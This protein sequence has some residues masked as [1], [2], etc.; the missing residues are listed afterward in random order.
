MTSAASTESPPTLGGEAGDAAGETGRLL[1]GFL[2]LASG[3][4]GLPDDAIT[5]NLSSLEIV[6]VSD[7]LRFFPNLDAIDLSDNKL[8]YKEVLEH[9]F[10][11][12]RL[13]KINL[14]CNQIGRLNCRRNPLATHI[15]SF[16]TLQSLDLSYN[17]LH[18]DVLIALASLPQLQR[19]NLTANCV[20]SIPPEE[21]LDGFPKLQEL[22]LDSNDLVQFDQWRSLDCLRS[23]RHLSLKHNRI[24]RL[25]DEEAADGLSRAEYE[26]FVKLEVLELQDNDFSGLQQHTNEF[27]FAS[28]QVQQSKQFEADFSLLQR[29]PALRTV[30]VSQVGFPRRLFHARV[31]TE[32][33]KRWYMSGNQSHTARDKTERAR[34]NTRGRRTFRQVKSTRV[35]RFGAMGGEND[36]FR[37]SA[38]SSFGDFLAT[39]NSYRNTSTSVGPGAGPSSP[40]ATMQ[41][42]KYGSDEDLQK[43]L[44]TDTLVKVNARSEK[45]SHETKDK[46]KLVVQPIDLIGKY[47]DDEAMDEI[48]AR[49]RAQIDGLVER[50]VAGKQKKTQQ[51]YLQQIPFALSSESQNIILSVAK[52]VSAQTA[53]HGENEDYFARY[54]AE[55]ILETP[56]TPPEVL[57]QRRTRN[58]GMHGDSAL[59]IQDRSAVSGVDVPID[60]KR[61][62]EALQDAMN[63]DDAT[64]A[65]GALM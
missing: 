5:A 25:R 28:S 31:E 60:I 45:M 63:R 40:N 57:Q 3:G 11:T 10:L 35:T 34:N 61:S 13:T 12:P 64:W 48:F 36:T 37:G 44:Y 27:S 33:T 21:S 58:G 46:E 55:Q 4:F 56:R 38:A 29:F 8:N 24:R 59:G 26:V 17:E 51:S 20:S 43:A 16:D 42:S 9:L 6:E 62:L 49:R 18:G 41:L 50:R 14:S 53:H 19:L 47:L 39:K 23:L 1:D 32:T 7:D 2:L 65:G 30:R 54:T 52:D 15:S 22:I